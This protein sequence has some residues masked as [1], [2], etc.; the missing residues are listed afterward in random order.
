MQIQPVKQLRGEVSVPGDKSISHRSIMFGALAK[1]T[2]E[3]THFLHGADCLSTIGCF[4]AMG[5]NIEDTPDR[6]LVHGKGLHGLSEP[7]SF[8]DVG[9]SGTT[10]RL[11]SGILSG[12]PFATTLSGDASLNS[13]PMK[14]IMEPL[15]MMG[16]DILSQNGNGCAPLLINSLLP[17]GQNP[18]LHAIHYH[19]KVA[20]AQVKSSVL[21]AGLY[22]DGLTLVTEPVL[23]RNHTELMLNGFGANVQTEIH[24][25]G[26]ATASILP[27]EELY[28]QK[29]LV[30]GDISSAAYFIAAALLVPGSELLIKNV[31][32]NPT[33]AGILE[34][35]R[36]MG[37]DITYLNE[38]C[39]SGEPTADLLVR[40]SALHGTTVEG[41]IIP[42]LIDEIPMIAVMAA[43]ADGTTVIRDAQELK[44]KES[45]RITVMVDNL[46]RMGADI[47]GTEDGMII[48][49]GRP[50]HGATI[51]SHL[52]H[53]VAMSFAV[54]GTIC[55]GTVD[56]L[57][58]DCVK[59]SYPEFYNDLYSLSK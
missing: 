2:T 32:T 49:G 46:K 40:T 34:I 20:S 22:A 50:L 57:N 15:G 9:N 18:S 19:S 44:V 58:G 10:T 43:F 30:P 33:R 29:I 48:H 54:A 31:G 28:G 41:A 56:I 17:A 21:L 14:R 24:S 47:E 25:D 16:A 12:Q 39:D 42:T 45:D 7:S 27:C 23:S 53:R 3:I 35:C 5:I 51:D 1:G 59:I 37:A 11:I 6:I 26:S 4:R 55:D 38:N 13:R 36:A 8:L 52:D